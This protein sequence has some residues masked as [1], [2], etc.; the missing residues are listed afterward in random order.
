MDSADKSSKKSKKSVLVVS[1]SHK[2]GNGDSGKKI[3]IKVSAAKK[4]KPD[5]PPAKKSSKKI[6]VCKSDD[7]MIEHTDRSSKKERKRSS[8]K[9]NEGSQKN[10]PSLIQQTMPKKDEKHEKHKKHEKHEKHQK[11]EK[12]HHK[13]GGG[14]GGENVPEK[15]S[16]E[17]SGK[18]SGCGKSGGSKSGEKLK[19]KKKIKD[20]GEIKLVKEAV[21]VA[22]HSASAR[23]ENEISDVEAEQPRMKPDK[24]IIKR[25]G[26]L[27]IGDA[28]F[29]I[30]DGA[31]LG[32]YGNCNI[33]EVGKDELLTF[34]YESISS[35]CKRIKIECTVLVCAAA[36]QKT[37]MLRLLLRGT[38]DNFKLRYLITDALG[39][40]IPD[41]LNH[42][43]IESFSM[44]S[45][46][47]LS[48][49][50]FESL[51]ELH[52]INFV[53]RDVKPAAYAFGLK[54]LNT[55]LFLTHFGLAKKFRG[56]A[57]AKLL[58][59]R[60]SVPF[61]G[62]VKY[63]SRTVHERGER[64]RKDDI[65]SWVFMITEFI[66][67]KA[68]SWRKSTNR[69]EILK[70]KS[71]FMSDDGITHLYS[72]NKKIP[73]EFRP[74]IHYVMSLEFS[75]SPDYMYIKKTLREAMEK[76]NIYPND[77]WEWDGLEKPVTHDD[78]TQQCPEDP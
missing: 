43:C 48:Y 78:S 37:H 45:A 44:S 69:D 10:K 17:E 61:M 47:R 59:P 26:K 58:A 33:R 35:K 75:S 32:D 66:D 68:L 30:V 18:G 3:K 24:T 8:N 34:R 71:F 50:T 55:K 42:L 11:H 49:E 38:I 60:K 41:L 29:D 77:P 6:I 5:A 20:N 7:N 39:F 19:A 25:G 15:E 16:E 31:V 40:T 9:F 12:Q 72:K 22:K 23:D 70:E 54:P 57:D 64:S 14:G 1:A 4:K 52:K 62:T 27:E 74:I 51:E 21:E 28:M 53:H 56:S 2:P 76:R 13:K 73:E 36:T 46:L 67:E 63:A 65:E